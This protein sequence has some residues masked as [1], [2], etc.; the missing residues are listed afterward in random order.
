MSAVERF[1]TVSVKFSGAPGVTSGCRACASTHR[2]VH[3]AMRLVQFRQLDLR[4]RVGDRRDQRPRLRQQRDASFGMRRLERPDGLGQDRRHRC[5]ARQPIPGR[6]DA[7]E[8]ILRGRG[9]ADQFEVG[10]EG[11]RTP[12]GAGALAVVHAA[13]QDGELFVGVAED[14]IVRAGLHR[15]PAL[16]RRGAAGAGP[17][18]CRARRPPCRGKFQLARISRVGL[19]GLYVT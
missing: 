18:H 15:S 7:F 10:S 9:P 19:P 17:Q 16:R 12:H 11:A 5:A 4:Q 2:P 1:N 14:R 3:S 13:A 6:V 8:R